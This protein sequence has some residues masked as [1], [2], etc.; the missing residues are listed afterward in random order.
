MEKVFDEDAVGLRA[1]V[2]GLVFE[3]KRSGFE[4]V[5]VSAGVAQLHQCPVM[6]PAIGCKCIKW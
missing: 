5:D 3:G 6:I 2:W 4:L 1:V